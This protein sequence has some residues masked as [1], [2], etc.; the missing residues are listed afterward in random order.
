VAEVIECEVL[1]VSGSSTEY[2]RPRRQLVS[3]GHMTGF[4]KDVV[5]GVLGSPFLVFRQNGAAATTT[6]CNFL[7]FCLFF[8]VCLFFFGVPTNLGF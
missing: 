4:S 7:F 2:R 8:V 3:Y 6:L 1:W 5:R